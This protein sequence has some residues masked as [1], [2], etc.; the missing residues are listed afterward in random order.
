LVSF[1]SFVKNQVSVGVWVY[2]W[3]FD[4]IPLI[5]LSLGLALKATKFE[6]LNEMNYFLDKCHLPKLNQD[7]V[8]N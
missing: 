2:F 7:V 5:N 6:N 8:T 4:L 1:D 3:V